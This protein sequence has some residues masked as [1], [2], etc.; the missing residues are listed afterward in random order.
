MACSIGLR[1]FAQLFSYDVNWTNYEANIAVKAWV[2]AAHRSTAIL[3][4]F[5]FIYLAKRFFNDHSPSVK[6]LT[7]FL[8]IQYALG[9]LTLI[10]AVGSIPLL[11]GSLHQLVAMGLVMCFL[12]LHYAV[13]Y[14]HHSQL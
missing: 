1:G 2:Q 10:Y 14:K 13:R 11:Y 5:V 12:H 8:G 6:A 7:I 4:V 3:L 9:V